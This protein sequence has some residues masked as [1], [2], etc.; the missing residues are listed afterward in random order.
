MAYS[1]NLFVWYKVNE[2]TKDPMAVEEYNELVA[3]LNSSLVTSIPQ[4]EEELQ[5]DE[6]PS[7]SLLNSVFFKLL[8]N[9]TFLLG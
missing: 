1:K 3:A 4:I 9:A 2:D 5:I 6:F 8:N 7:V